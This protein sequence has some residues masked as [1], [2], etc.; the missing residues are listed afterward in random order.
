MSRIDRRF[1]IRI[2]VS[3]SIQRTG[4]PEERTGCDGHDP[5]SSGDTRRDD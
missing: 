4:I 1:L 5:P 3:Q 2:L